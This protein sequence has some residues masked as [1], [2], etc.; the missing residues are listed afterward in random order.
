MDAVFAVGSFHV[1]H[2]A[3]SPLGHQPAVHSHRGRT[4]PPRS[5]LGRSI[6]P[7]NCR[8]RLGVCSDGVMAIG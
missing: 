7:F 8:H 5:P 6:R 1:A 2:V 4:R 3:Y